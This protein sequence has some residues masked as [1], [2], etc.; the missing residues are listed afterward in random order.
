M[1]TRKGSLRKFSA[2]MIRDLVLILV[3]GVALSHAKSIS[4]KQTDGKKSVY[5]NEVIGSSTFSQRGFSGT[6]IAPNE[7]T[8]TIGGNFIRHNIDT[9]D[10]TTV[11]SQAFIQQHWAGLGASFRFSADLSRILVRHSSRSIFRHSS[12]AKFDYISLPG[13]EVTQIANN[14]EVQ[15]VIFAPTGKALIY[16][17]DN[18][19]YY[20]DNDGVPHVI[21]NDGIPGVVYNGVPDWVYEEEIL[22]VDYA[23]WFSPDGQ[24]LAYVRFNDTEV[25]EFMYELYGE[26]ELQYPQEVHL[27]YPKAGT[28]N[29]TVDLTLARLDGSVPI[30]LPVPI[31]IVGED[32]VLGSVFWINAQTMGTI[33]MNR[34]QNVGVIVTYDT[35]SHEMREVMNIEEPD[36]WIEI[37]TP[38]CHSSGVCYLINNKDNWP[39]LT[40]VNT[41]TGAVETHTPDG[42]SVIS[43]YGVDPSG[44]VYYLAAPAADQS[45]YRHVYSTSYGCLT[46]DYVVN[47]KGDLCV[48]AAGSFSTDFSRFV[49]TCNGPDVQ[50]VEVYQT[51]GRQH[52]RVWEDNSGMVELLKGYDLGH[53]KYFHVPV[54]GG[55]NASVMMIIPSHLDFDNVADADKGKHPLLVRVY[56]GPAS[57]TVSGAFGVGFKDYQVTNKSYIYVEIDGRGTARKGINMMFAINNKLGTIEMEDQLTV[58]QYIINHY[59]FIDKN[60]V[61]LWGWSYGGYATAMTLALD[62]NKVFKCGIIVAP[63]TAYKFYDTIYTER[64]MGIDSSAANYEKG[65]V[66]RDEYIQVLGKHKF[67]L[68]HGN[69]DDNVHYQQSMVLARQLQLHD[70]MFEMMSYPNEAHGISGTQLHLYHAFD[71]FWDRCFN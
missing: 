27:R 2:K 50:R 53:R 32:H 61:G 20:V 35:T 14:Q 11:L 42:V 40:S 39:R 4:P 58:T 29:P 43:I 31:D 3:V 55:F 26:G 23:S 56:G 34:R 12:V 67:L 69:A 52:I 63:V 68:V 70:I 60:R 36:G 15:V 8:A 47:D 5:F 21:T 6:W 41:A 10:N 17:Q 49:M 46:C 22:G 7:V 65:D 44:V 18:N 9:G 37:N 30:V 25:Q 45:F 33:W 48:Y 1:L 13:L 64:Y 71:N 57:A 59:A 66:S 62:T 51:Q 54:G 19:I 38:R 24:H 28:T 16:V